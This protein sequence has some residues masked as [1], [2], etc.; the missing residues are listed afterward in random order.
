[1][2]I[3]VG[4]VSSAKKAVQLQKALE[5][6][7]ILVKLRNV[8][9]KAKTTDDTIEVLVLESEADAAREILVENGL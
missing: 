3:V 5:E 6:E 1:M 9:A 7:G 2:W 4:M 8:S